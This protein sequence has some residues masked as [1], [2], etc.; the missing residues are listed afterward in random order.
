MLSK[1]IFFIIVSLVLLSLACGVTIN[2]PV[3]EVKTGPLR[4]EEIFVPA[5]DESPVNLVLAFGAGE[6]RIQPGA[7]NGLVE[8]VAIYNVDDLKPVVAVVG[9]TVRLETGNLELNG[10]PSFRKE[11]RN[12][13]DLRLSD[14][15]INL[16]INAGAYKGDIELGGLAIQTLKIADGASDVQLRFSEPN[17]LEMSTLRYDTGASSVELLSL[18]NANFDRLVFKGGA[19]DYHLDFSG[20]LKRPAD[21]TVDAGISSVTIIVPEGVSARVFFDGGL[22]NVDI[23]GAWEKSGDDYF[24][25]GEGPRL[26]I[27]V[28]IGAGNLDLRTR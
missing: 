21:V 4:T 15:P 11:L 19:G 10:I 7:E 12:E 25:S 5:Q 1:P 3:T 27:N 17:K 8:G 16:T 6:L 28:N 13:W 20:E 14:H 18:A 23:S 24:L 26:T 2:L 9:S 22:S